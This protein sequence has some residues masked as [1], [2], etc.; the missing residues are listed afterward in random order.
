MDR[1]DLEAPP[2]I[3]PG[4]KVLQ[5]GAAPP[6]RYGALLRR[7]DIDDVGIGEVIHHRQPSE[8]RRGIRRERRD[9]LR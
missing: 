2:G 5:T 7:I 1:L 9:Q 3:E 8:G 6:S 4:I